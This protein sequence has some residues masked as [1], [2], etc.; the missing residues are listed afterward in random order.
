MYISQ[1]IYVCHIPTHAHICTS[2]YIKTLNHKDSSYIYYIMKW[3]IYYLCKY[4]RYSYY[5]V[6]NSILKNKKNDIIRVQ[7]M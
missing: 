2:I 4:L 3:I 1:Y 5:K 7:L 6:K